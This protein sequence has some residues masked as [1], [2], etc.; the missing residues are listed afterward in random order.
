MDRISVFILTITVL[1]ANLLHA[2]PPDPYISYT[3]NP[4]T[5]HIA[6][7]WKND[8]G[9]P[10]RSLGNLKNYLALQKKRLVF[11]MNGGMY[12]TDNA[13]LGLFV[14]N[15]LQ[16]TWLNTRNGEGNF[17]MKPNGVLYITNAGK[18]VICRT[19]NYTPDKHITFATQSGPMLV[20]DG[21]IHPEFKKGSTRVNIRNGVG[22]LPDGKLLF[23]MSKGEVNLYD[24]ALYFRDRGC[25]NALFLD[26]FVSR[27]YLPTKNCLQTDGDFG[28]MVG[29]WE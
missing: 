24:F 28:V 18:A 19:E 2:Q 25:K 5:Q 8:K 3:V 15:G 23:A 26:G 1:V 16:I 21:A 7:Y 11:G 22:L 9:E 4:K 12:M 10:L 6:L 17:Y 20:I 14:Q 27:T 29:V 13:P